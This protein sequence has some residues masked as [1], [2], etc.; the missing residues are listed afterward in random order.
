VKIKLTVIPLTLILWLAGCTQVPLINLH[1]SIAKIGNAGQPAEAMVKSPAIGCNPDDSVFQ[2]TYWKSGNKKAPVLYYACF[3]DHDTIEEIKSNYIWSPQA[4]N[5]R[6]LTITCIDTQAADR[7]RLKIISVDDQNAEA[8]IL[9][10]E[11]HARSE[12]DINPQPGKKYYFTIYKIVQDAYVFMKQFTMDMPYPKAAA[13]SG[14]TIYPVGKNYGKYALGWGIGLAVTPYATGTYDNYL[15]SPSIIL[16]NNV[17]M[18]DS[19]STTTQNIFSL[20]NIGI[21]VSWLYGI[22]G[23]VIIN[24]HEFKSPQ[25]FFGL[26]VIEVI[27]YF[28]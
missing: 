11:M 10:Q 27:G 2:L 25:L 4:S 7:Y 19:N 14:P 16:F 9:D 20:E 28:L 24:L 15:F 13:Y 22:T 3:K 12:I 8:L 18:V 5:K 1:A 17:V 21:G 23:G 6:Q 26:N